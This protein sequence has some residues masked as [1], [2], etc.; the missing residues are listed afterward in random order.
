MTDAG[1]AAQRRRTGGRP[2]PA[3]RPLEYNATVVNRVDLTDALSIF[4]IQPDKPPKKRPW[5]TA[6][7]SCVLGLNNVEKPELGSARRPMSIASP[8]EA[9]GPIE[10]YI[11]RV[12]KPESQNPLTHLMWRLEGGDRMY[13]RPVAAGVFTIKD[14][15]GMD[16]PRIRLM[17]AAGTG[18]APF[19]SM[20]RSEISR[21]PHADLSNWVLLHGA[22]IPPISATAMSSSGYR[23]PTTSVTGGQ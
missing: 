22:L 14:T 5:F 20:L 11:R 8:P 19:V 10:F 12:A 3:A 17:V 16:D 4:Q 21:N 7:Q 15:V 6:G 2:L 1:T 9:D 13:M 23:R 18:V